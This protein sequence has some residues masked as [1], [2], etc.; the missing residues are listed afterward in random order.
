MTKIQEVYGLL[1]EDSSRQTVDLVGWNRW[2][3]SVPTVRGSNPVERIGRPRLGT[4]VRQEI[5]PPA[6]LP[7]SYACDKSLTPKVLNPNHR[8]SNHDL[9]GFVLLTSIIVKLTIN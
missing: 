3:I 6:Y 2:S 4:L 1:I 5:Q 8:D 7:L 9:S